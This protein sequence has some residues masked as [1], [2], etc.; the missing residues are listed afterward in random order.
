MQAGSV[1]IATLM[2]TGIC[3]AV[4]LAPCGSVSKGLLHVADVLQSLKEYILTG[5]TFI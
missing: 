2:L 1:P 5:L 3:E 4:E